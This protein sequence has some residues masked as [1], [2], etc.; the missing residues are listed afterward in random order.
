M[1]RGLMVTA[2]RRL[3]M[4]VRLQA[5]GEG[6]TRRAKRDRQKTKYKDQRT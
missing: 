2:G 4:R 3:L 5:R 6:A 1:V